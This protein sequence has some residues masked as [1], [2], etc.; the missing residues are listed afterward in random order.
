MKKIAL[1]IF[2][3][4]FAGALFA[5]KSKYNKNITE[6]N[7]L[8]LENNY[9]MALHSY[10]AAYAIDSTNANINYKIGLCYLNIPSKKKNAFRFMEKAAKNISKSYDEDEPGIKCAPIDAI[11]YHAKAQHYSGNFQLAIDEFQKYQSTV[12]KKNKDRNEDIERQIAMCNNAIEFSKKPENITIKNLGDSINSEYPDY[13]S[14]VNADESLLLFTSRRANSTGGERGTDGHFY[15]D[16]Y[17]SQAK[18]DLSWSSSNKLSAMINT[19]TNEATIGISPDGQKLYIYKDEDIYYST[20]VGET[21][22]GLFSF[23]EEVNSKNFEAHITIASVGK[24]MFFSSDR[25][26]GLGGNDL[27]RCT[28]LSNGKWSAPVNLGPAI[29]TKY[30]EDAPYIHP[31]GKKFFFA[32]EG[33]NTIGGLDIFY[34]DLSF[35]EAGN[36]LWKGPFNLGMPLNTTDDDEFYIPTADG[37]H[38]YFSSAREGG[39]GDQDIYTAG[40]PESIKVDPLLLLKGV[41]TF[42]SLN[43]PDNMVVNVYDEETGELIATTR[44]NFIT[45]K[46]LLLINPGPKAKKYRINYEA[47]GYQ[48]V[49]QTISVEA[50]KE[51]KV[52]DNDLELE[53]IGSKK[54]APGTLSLSGTVKN[55][56]GVFIPGVQINIKDNNTGTLLKT[57]TTNSDIVSYTFV[58]D[59]GKNY[60]ISFEASGYLFQSQNID[61]PKKSD[62]LELKKDIVLELIRSGAKMVMNNI[63]FDKNKA[64][65]RKQSLVEIETVKKLLKENPKMVIEISG[66]TDSQGNDALNEKLSQARAQSVVNYL[67][68]N[69]IPTT[70]M[71]AIGYGKKQPVAPNTL[72]NGKPDL[73]GQ[74]LNRRVEMKILDHTP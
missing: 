48:P 18:K 58:I 11:Y 34:A 61:I 36:L 23:G 31:D 26:G 32:S 71:K 49:S 33:H 41:L 47:T 43:R 74:Q 29:N 2:L 17:I 24:S 6:G 62:Y 38:A 64:T 15:E 21:W 1:L 37:K 16:I 22:T 53:L 20:L 66:H 55:E 56:K 46:Y 65:L 9:I 59:R 72:P 12:G 30:N 70:Q 25:P 52:I 45:G 5:Q 8:F 57:Y 60:N 51:Y 4:L 10:E 40:L 28:K 67:V 69:G 35:D 42:D 54:K 27:Y 14:V 39:Y 73:A 44:P 7:Y 13:G 3:F 63:F 50:L 19:N 68:K